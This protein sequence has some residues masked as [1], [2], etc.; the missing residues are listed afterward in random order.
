[1]G[2]QWKKQGKCKGNKGLIEGNLTLNKR[3]KMETTMS[4]R[5]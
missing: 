3:E 1:M 4:F 2:T 5:V